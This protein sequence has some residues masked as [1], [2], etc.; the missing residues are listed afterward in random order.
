MSSKFW[1][2]DLS[3]FITPDNYFQVIPTGEMKF[4]EQLNAACRLSLYYSLIVAFGK[5]DL[6]AFAVALIVF[7]I[8][9][10][11]YYNRN[12]NNYKKEIERYMGIAYDKPTQSYCYKPTKQNPFMNV[13][14]ND[15]KDFPNRPS[16]CRI[17]QP[18]VK[19]TVNNLFNEGQYHEVDDIFGRKTSSRQF[20]TNPITTIPNDQEGFAKWLYGT[21]K[22]TC[23]EGNG[24]QCI[25]Y[26]GR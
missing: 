5:R 14:Y 2:N 12:P 3:S 4:E 23:K 24:S 19:K 21:N 18:S 20:V 9:Y 16:A 13:S 26:A 22:P 15:I 17:T 11:L 1:A 6:N 8:T 10:Y 25:L 7:A